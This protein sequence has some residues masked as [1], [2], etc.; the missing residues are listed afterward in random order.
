METGLPLGLI[1]GPDCAETTLTLASGECVTFIS[2]GVAGECNAKGELY[3]F[4][5]TR[6]ASTQPAAGLAKTAKEFGQEDDIMVIAI[7]RSAA[8]DYA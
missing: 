4:E 8:A 3:G 1:E 2:D 5:R 6:A 7:E